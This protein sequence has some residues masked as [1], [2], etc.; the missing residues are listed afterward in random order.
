M[1]EYHGNPITCPR[2]KVIAIEGGR[3]TCGHGESS[4]TYTCP[5]C[6]LWTEARGPGD[7]NTGWL[8]SIKKFEPTLSQKPRLGDYPCAAEPGGFSEWLER[9]L[10]ELAI[11]S[12]WEVRV[13]TCKQPGLVRVV[14]LGANGATVAAA[15]DQRERMS[16]EEAVEEVVV[17]LAGVQNGE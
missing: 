13:S 10:R 6:R 5:K 4:C 11:L 9:R 16:P 2:C 8:E 1:A 7:I 14:L 15:I 3:G 17:R 12:P